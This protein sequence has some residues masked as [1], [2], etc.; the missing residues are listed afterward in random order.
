MLHVY[1]NLM[2]AP[3]V[4][5]TEDEGSRRFLLFAQDVVV[6]DSWFARSRVHHGHLLS[7][8]RMSTQLREY[9]PGRLNGR[10]LGGRKVELAGLAIV[11]L[12]EEGLLGGLRLRH[13]DAA[14]GIFVEA[15]DDPRAFYPADPGQFSLAVVEE[16]IDEGAVWGAG[17]GMDHESA[18]LV[19]HQEVIIFED[20]LE[21]DVLGQDF[22]GLGFGEIDGDEI[23]FTHRGPRARRG[24]VEK[25]MTRL[26]EGLDPGTREIAQFTRQIEIEAFPGTFADGDS[27]GGGKRGSLGCGKRI[28]EA[29]LR[30]LLAPI[31]R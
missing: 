6:G 30:T 15:M 16:G 22:G 21:R 11:K 14:T 7:V 25:D 4:E 26:D 27:H 13:H 8:H 1:T 17:G 29:R 5:M 20:D 28:E 9:T 24:S 2:G 19:D 18:S 31:L 3:G 10:P 12:L 23:S